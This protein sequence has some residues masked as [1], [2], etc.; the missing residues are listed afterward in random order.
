MHILNFSQQRKSRS[1]NI[2]KIFAY[3]QVNI[4]VENLKTFLNIYIY[5]DVYTENN[6]YLYQKHNHKPR[7]FFEIRVIS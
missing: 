5:I 6:I 2:S 3:K 4:I 7:N 1:T